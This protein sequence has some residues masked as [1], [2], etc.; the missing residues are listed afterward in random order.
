M[1]KRFFNRILQA[2]GMRD[3]LNLLE[4]KEYDG[5]VG[6]ERLGGRWKLKEQGP[7]EKM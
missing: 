3:Y 7:N 5:V 6:K 2:K 1:V 4:G